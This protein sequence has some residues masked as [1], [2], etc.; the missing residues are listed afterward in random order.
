VGG[1]RLRN[2]MMLTLLQTKANTSAGTAVP[3]SP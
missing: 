2:D 3:V 1:S